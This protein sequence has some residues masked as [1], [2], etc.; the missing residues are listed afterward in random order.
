[1]K[2]QQLPTE[3]P[4]TDAERRE[5]LR[6]RAALRAALREQAEKKKTEGNQ[7]QAE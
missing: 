6:R 4:A 3:H 2:R 5:W 7:E 1:M